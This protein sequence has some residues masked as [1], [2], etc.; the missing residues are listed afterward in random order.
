VNGN[1]QAAARRRRNTALTVLGIGVL[2]ALSGGAG[3][4]L[5][6]LP[7][8][9]LVSVCARLFLSR[10]GA[11]VLVAGMAVLSGLSNYDIAGSAGPTG[12]EIG[13]AVLFVLLLVIAVV[14]IVLDSVA[15]FV[16]RFVWRSARWHPPIQ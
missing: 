14:G 8:F 7:A 5:A 10:A 3:G 12:R 9:A 11:L 6:E 15:A 2:V 13:F 4:V 1:A 16:W